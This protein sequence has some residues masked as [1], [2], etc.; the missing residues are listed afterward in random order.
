[1]ESQGKRGLSTYCVLTGIIFKIFTRLKDLDKTGLACGLGELLQ[2]ATGSW[3]DLRAFG[4]ETSLDF[5][6][7][8]ALVKEWEAGEGQ[9]FA[10]CLE[11]TF[12]IIFPGRTFLLQGSQGWSLAS[13]ALC[14]IKQPLKWRCHMVEGTEALSYKTRNPINSCL[15]PSKPIV[16]PG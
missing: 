1:M 13:P 3:A 16:S 9:L 5:G 7:K 10:S 4:G 11:S 14:I 2:T 12:S 6:N 15:P 8:M